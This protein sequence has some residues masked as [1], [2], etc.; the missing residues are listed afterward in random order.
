MSLKEICEISLKNYR[1]SK[2]HIVIK[3]INTFFIQLYEAI[4]NKEKATFL[5][6]VKITFIK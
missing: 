1:I 4:F 2:M 5:F 6:Q 3:F